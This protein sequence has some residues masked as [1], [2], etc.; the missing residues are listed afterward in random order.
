MR[1]ESLYQRWQGTGPDA[2]VWIDYELLL[3]VL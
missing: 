3:V 2:T 1:C